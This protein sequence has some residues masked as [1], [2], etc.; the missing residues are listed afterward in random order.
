MT[1]PSSK[2]TEREEI[3]SPLFRKI[4]WNKLIP[5]FLGPDERG[6][7]REDRHRS[8]YLFVKLL[9]GCLVEQNKVVQLVANFSFRPFLLLG[10]A[11]SGSFFLLT[12]LGRVGLSLR[13]LLGRL[14]TTNT[15]M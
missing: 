2:R 13:I 9:V 11:S 5:F 7:E 3:D 15:Y 14:Q 1:A 4:E 8:Y 12:G 10:L 6:V